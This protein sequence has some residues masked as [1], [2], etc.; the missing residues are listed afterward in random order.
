MSSWGR[1]YRVAVPGAVVLLFA[2][3]AGT[4]LLMHG[5]LA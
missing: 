3:L 5:V 1:L 4:N 2:L